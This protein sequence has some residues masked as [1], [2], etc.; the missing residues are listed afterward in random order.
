MRPSFLTEIGSG[1]A[2]TEDTLWVMRNLT[3]A[4]KT[5]P[6]VRDLAVRLTRLFPQKDFRAEVY[7][8]WRFVRDRIRYVRDIRGVETLQMPD[9]TLQI[10]QGDCD[11]KSVLLASLLESIGHPTRFK[12]MSFKPGKFSH[13]LI[14]TRI[15]GSGPWVPLETT[16]PVPFGWEPP[17]ALE[18]LVIDNH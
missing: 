11:D 16:E 17:D 8:L 3:L 4:G 7:A 9:V 14:E 12:A 13:V 10:G 5:H 15:G 1:R 18:G 6:A 2:G